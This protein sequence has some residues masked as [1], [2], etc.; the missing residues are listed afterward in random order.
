MNGGDLSLNAFSARRMTLEQV[1]GARARFE[2]TLRAA[3]M[4]SLFQALV[5][6]SSDVPDLIR[7]IYRLRAAWQ[8][9]EASCLAGLGAAVENDP[10]PPNTWVMDSP[11][12]Y[13][14]DA[15]PMPPGIH[16]LTQSIS[17][18]WWGGQSL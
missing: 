7:E 17:A 5:I 1:D 16:P 18:R 11:W 10:R 3:P 4:D 6:S 14:T 2:A 8:N 13:I 12:L 15:L 9:L